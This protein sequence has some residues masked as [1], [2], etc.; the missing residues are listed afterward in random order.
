[1]NSEAAQETPG[2]PL[3]GAL[4]ISGDSV[5][6]GSELL[7]QEKLRNDLLSRLLKSWLGSEGKLLDSKAVLLRH[8]LGKRCN[9]QIELMILP[10]PGALVERRWVVG[11]VYAE[12]HGAGAYEMLQEL[13]SLGFSGSRFFVPQPLAY[14]PRWKLLLLS[15]AEGD[16]LR[17]SILGDSDVSWKMKEAASWLV[18]FHQSG[19][20]V[21]SRYTFRRHMQ[22]L[23]SHKRH[24]I[25][26]L[27]D[28]DKRLERMLCRIEERGAK[29][30][31][32][33][34]RPTH[35]DFSP[36]HL[37]FNGECVTALDFDEFHQYDPMFDVAHFMAHL[38][39]LGL[40]HDGDLNR[41]D[42]LGK[43]FQTEYRSYARDYSETRVR[44]YRAV[45]YFKLA[46]ITAVVVR[47]P[48]W[49]EAVEVFLRS[50]ERMLRFES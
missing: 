48:G 32:W 8:V 42:E 49:E 44:F 20:S 17:S 4:A 3:A 50:A 35:L 13:R 28:L 36:D 43:I 27:P 45:S 34:P 24:L 11:K 1:M 23:V 12:H 5:L 15:W 6:P 33:T 9:F 41:F 46:Y 37:V 47:P 19:V 25:T 31:G 30:S 2:N 40:R 16:L 18:K 38:K 14:D 39:L 21:G 10:A 26:V 29:L 22:T 7:R